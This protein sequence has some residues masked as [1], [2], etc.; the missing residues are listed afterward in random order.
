[1]PAS[2]VN[3]SAWLIRLDKCPKQVNQVDCD[4]AAAASSLVLAH[5]RARRDP[6]GWTD[7]ENGTL[8]W[9]QTCGDLDGKVW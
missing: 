4:V 2:N 7:R 3:W 6:V 9:D 5:S 1:M 8:S